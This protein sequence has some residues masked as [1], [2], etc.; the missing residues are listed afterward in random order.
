MGG[1]LQENRE[2][3]KK[4]G[5][6]I[7][8]DLS[9]ILPIISFFLVNTCDNPA[10]KTAVVVVLVLCM[11][12]S[13]SI[14]FQSFARKFSYTAILIYLI[15]F[16]LCI[17]FSIAVFSKKCDSPKP[18][19]EKPGEKTTINNIDNSKHVTNNYTPDVV[20]RVLQREDLVALL[21]ELADKRSEI[22]VQHLTA[23]PEDGKIVDDVNAF[24]DKNGYENVRTSDASYFSIG[25]P[26]RM[27]T[28]KSETA[29]GRSIYKVFVY[30]KY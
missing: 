14:C 28:V 16:T 12:L 6:E 7:L 15:L 23:V 11:L 26:S 20:K 4:A 21:K 8:A 24:L 22:W 10:L 3:T 25:I 5:R 13:V 30:S 17:S 18:E 9:A 27:L 19:G 1:D 2:F 29:D